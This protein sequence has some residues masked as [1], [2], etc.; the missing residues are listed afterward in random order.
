[1]L[2]VRGL[3]ANTVDQIPTEKYRIPMEKAMFYSWETS[4]TSDPLDTNRFR[5]ESS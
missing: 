1:M 4:M 3:F 5:W 2:S